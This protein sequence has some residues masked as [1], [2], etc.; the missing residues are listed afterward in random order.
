M[1]MTNN[2]NNANAL[3]TQLCISRC[4]KKI[5]L[6]CKGINCN[7]RRLIDNLDF[8]Y[9]MEWAII[10]SKDLKRV[11]ELFVKSLGL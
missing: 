5:T 7:L 11:M 4:G 6:E 9:S 1:L 2:F 8:H 10:V 3:L